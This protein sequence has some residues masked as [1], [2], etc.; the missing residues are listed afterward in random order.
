MALPNDK[1]KLLFNPGIASVYGYQGKISD[2]T[3][4]LAAAMTQHQLR[5]VFFVADF[6]VGSAM[7]QKS[8]DL[9][10]QQLPT[11][12]IQYFS[13]A[14]HNIHKTNTK[15]FVQM[16]IDWIQLPIDD[17]QPDQV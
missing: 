2:L 3:H 15:L 5:V 7:T 11:A 6:E 10:S 1:W 14:W 4:G 17:C 13:K 9:I 16:L 8:L 12:K